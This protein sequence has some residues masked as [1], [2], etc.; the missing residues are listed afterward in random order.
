MDRATTAERT[1]LWLGHQLEAFPWRNNDPTA[2]MNTVSFKSHD[3]K[4]TAFLQLRWHFLNKASFF[5]LRAFLKIKNVFLSADL[6]KIIP[7]FISRRPDCAAAFILESHRLCFL[8]CSLR[9]Q[10]F[11]HWLWKEDPL[12]TE[13]DTLTP[14]AGSQ[15][16]PDCGLWG[17]AGLQRGATRT[18]KLLPVDSDLCARSSLS[19]VHFFLEE[20]L[21]GKVW[22]DYNFMFEITEQ[23]LQHDPRSLW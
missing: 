22:Q 7:A 16:I 8:V 6:W 5:Q 15:M 18:C 2:H 1:S 11:N 21:A 10:Q 19:L 4:V 3:N 12:W 23:K 20:K 17:R 14:T 9:K 13:R